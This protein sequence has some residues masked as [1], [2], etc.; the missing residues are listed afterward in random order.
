MG[1]KYLIA[2]AKRIAD[3]YGLWYLNNDPDRQSKLQELLLGVPEK[4]IREGARSLIQY[5][6]GE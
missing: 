4:K 2:H 6:Y 3:Q 1:K 5:R